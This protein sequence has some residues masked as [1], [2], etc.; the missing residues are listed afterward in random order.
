MKT[1]KYLL[2]LLFGGILFAS[3]SDF[4][5]KPPIDE[6]T[7]GEF[8]QNE[9]HARTFMYDIYPT[10]FAGYGSGTT[11]PAWIN[12]IGDDG[13]SG[14]DQ[15][16]FSPSVIP[17]TDDS[18]N[19][20]NVRRA[21]Y[22]IENAPRMNEPEGTINHWVGIG[23]FLRGYFYSSLTFQYGDVPYFDHVLQYSKNKEDEAYMYKDRDPRDF[24]VDKIIED[25]EFALTNVRVNDGALQINRYVVAALAS[26]Y[27]LREATFQKYYYHNN[28]LATK[29]LQLAKK[30]SELVLSG[31]YSLS[32]NYKALFTSDDLSANSEVIMYRKYMD[33]ILAHSMV[34]YNNS[35]PQGGVSKSLTE[36]FLRS[37]G[38][39]IYYNNAYWLAPTAE[40]FFLDRDPRLSYNFRPQYYPQG[41]NNTPFAY[42][43]SGYS[44]RKYTDDAWMENGNPMKDS[45]LLSGGRNITNAPC[46]R[47]G[48]VL[49]NYAEICYELEAITG[50]NLFNQE[51]LDMSINKLRDRVGMPRL[52]EISG[53]PAV[54][55]VVY[56]DP[57][58][59]QW[60]PDN[61][62]SSML[63]EI[64][65][66]RRVEL[67][68]E[69]GFRSVDLKRWHKL[70]YLCNQHNPDFRYG[71]YIR[72]AD[73]PADVAKN[74][75]L[76]Y[77][78]DPVSVDTLDGKL[79]EGYIIKNIGTI[80]A[81]PEARNYVK[82]IPTDQ[83]T[84]YKNKSYTLT[85][86]KEWQ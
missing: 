71:A 8:W 43:L 60:E 54:N 40:A 67:C 38:F 14:G 29:C 22:V 23:H 7:D 65:R 44:W 17:A 15:G 68:L 42:T 70:D 12:D 78:V 57:Q 74:V 53:M 30:A 49:L 27:M 20:V 48:E 58:R 45:P 4:I 32:P 77:K 84:Q 31:P 82:P 61:D 85:Q 21:N 33:G 39:P 2:C 25:F 62:V 6:F 5:D 80:R 36:S 56:D 47:L 26:R 50:E 64:R 79:Q 10:L 83:I 55:G 13:V 51:I 76:A 28:A 34:Q 72:L 63:W 81:L 69:G 59:T 11:V 18:W 46:L 75:K 73:F 16:V 41:G 3:C 86:T 24:V 1:Y 35:Q 66:E 19:F 37:D 9:K 52:Q